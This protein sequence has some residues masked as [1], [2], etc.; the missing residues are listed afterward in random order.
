MKIGITCYPTYGGSGAVATELG[1]SLAD[2]GPPVGFQD[3]LRS[4]RAESREDV[5]VQGAF[6]LQPA[7]RVCH[8]TGNM[9]FDGGI[10]GRGD[11]GW[12]HPVV[13]PKESAATGG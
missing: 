11:W 8:G 6:V 7:L 1:L 9:T 13:A 10:P 4:L 3:E 12:C 2:R 5:V